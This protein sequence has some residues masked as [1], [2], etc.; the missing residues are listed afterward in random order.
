MTLSSDNVIHDCCSNHLLPHGITHCMIDFCGSVT[1]VTVFNKQTHSQ[2]PTE[3][4]TCACHN[5][6]LVHL[7]SVTHTCSVR[8]VRGSEP[9]SHSFLSGTSTGASLQYQV[10]QYNVRLWRNV[11]YRNVLGY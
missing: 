7:I 11:G 5:P 4:T 8:G 9:C 6:A 3:H 2:Q 10:L 1:D